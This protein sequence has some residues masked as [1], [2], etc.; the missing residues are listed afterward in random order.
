VPIEI[1]S[2]P[3]DP[4]ANSFASR[5]EINTILAE[6]IPF[7]P[8]WVTTG[9][10][11]ARK[12]ITARYLIER[13]FS[14]RKRLVREKGKAP[15]YVIGR[16]WTGEIA[17]DT[18]ALSW[19]RVGMLDRYG[20]AIPDGEIP[21]DLKVAQA[22]LAGQLHTD[23]SIDN[24]IIAQGITRIKAASVELSFR[25]DLDYSISYAIPQ[26]VFDIIPPSWYIEETVEAVSAGRRARIWNL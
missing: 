10:E 23:R 20:R 17:T 14:G 16:V 22:E 21:W 18:Q 13:E 15:Y 1:I 2:T 25:E 26:A 3:G 9:D 11:A 4:T 7:D 8:A 12:I 6:R 24:D 5:D 19:G